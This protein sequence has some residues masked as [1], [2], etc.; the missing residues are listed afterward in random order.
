MPAR[1]YKV[2]Q[3][4]GLRPEH[5]VSDRY[6][7]AITTIAKGNS[8]ETSAFTVANELVCARL[9]AAIGLPMPAYAIVERDG[10]PYFAS[11]DFNIEGQQLPPFNVP[12]ITNEQPALVCGILVFDI[13]TLNS[14]RHDT[15]IA[16]ITGRIEAAT[17][18]E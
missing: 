18:A 1:R 12:R 16:F 4:G 7:V 11:L 14:D 17:H 3:W 8:P 9:G 6:D 5:G 13:W 2:W 15:N 10:E